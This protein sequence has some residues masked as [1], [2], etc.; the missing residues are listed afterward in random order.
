[1]KNQIF[2]PVFLFALV[3][4]GLLQAQ[5]Y[6][7]TLSW[8]NQ[9]HSAYKIEPQSYQNYVIAGNRY[10]TSPNNNIYMSEFSEFSQFTWTRTHATTLNLQTFWKSFCKSTYP[11]GYF[12]VSAGT[13]GNANHAYAML[14]N[15]TG[16]KMWERTSSLANGIQFGGACPSVNGGFFACGG[17]NNGSAV[18]KFDSYG[19]LLWTQTYGDN[20]YAW[21]I[22]AAGG[23]GGGY[24]FAGGGGVT[25]IDADGNVQWSSDVSL[26]LSPDGSAYDYTEFE[27]ILLLPTNDG[28]IVTGSCFS[29]QHSGVYTARF[30][31]NG[32]QM[33]SKV[34]DVVNYNAMG[35]PVCWVN[36][37]VVSGSNEITTSWRRGPVSSGGT[38]YYQ[39]TSFTGT[40]VG[41]VGSMG[42]SIPVREAFMT[43]AHQKWA[44]GG[45]PGTGAGVYA[46]T[47]AS[48]S[49]TGDVAGDDRNVP[50]AG[51]TML[52][53]QTN[54]LNSMPE[55]DGDVPHPAS[56]TFY[57]DL[58]VY[59]NPSTGWV[60]IG[61]TFEA[62]ALL[63]V[64][65][66]QGQLVLERTLQDGDMLLDVDL[67]G[68]YPGVYNITVIG[69]TGMVSKKVS[70]Q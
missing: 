4:S 24:L 67:S 7:S 44:V 62:D 17:S 20:R 30:N 65:D 68:Q 11:L 21:S 53:R 5:P 6:E 41:G 56:R 66:M 42:N 1:M 13:S 35:T 34:N 37:A 40:N 47:S 59:P 52:G 3:N 39:R 22:K 32:V 63:R 2:L 36:N 16:M 10:F 14:T 26:P 23:G 69:K 28:F 70:I 51:L 46:Y 31:Y 12:V 64:T 18:C 49:F 25:R 54:V 60:N 33:W 8:H 27:E 58:N 61:G 9:F 48:L 55:F 38:M 43:R 29:S 57:A 50:E 15:A 19:N 45:I